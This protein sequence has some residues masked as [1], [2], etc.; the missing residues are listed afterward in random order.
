MTTPAE[1]WTVFAVGLLLGFSMCAIPCWMAWLQ[2]REAYCNLR[3]RI[4]EMEL[5]SLKP[6]RDERNGEPCRCEYCNDD[7]YASCEKRRN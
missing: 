1:N 5:N 4:L 3:K 2:F 7:N 6:A